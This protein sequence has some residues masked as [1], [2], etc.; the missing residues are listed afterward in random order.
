[1]LVLNGCRAKAAPDAGFLQEPKLMTTSK[2]M[3]FNRAWA[4]PKYSDKRYVEIYVAPVNTDYVMKQNTWEKATLAEA[5]RKDV[6]KNVHMLADYLRNSF[7]KAA[8]KDPTRKFTVV[9]HPG[10]DTVILEMA[11]VQAVPSKAELQAIA[12]PPQSYALAS[13]TT[14]FIAVAALSP[15]PEAASRE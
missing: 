2:D 15:S 10:P 12:S 1:L 9:D 7:I 4:N 13:M 6:E 11:I 5:N 3:P 8:E 14:L